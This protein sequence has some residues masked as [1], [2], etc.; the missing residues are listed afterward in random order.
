MSTRIAAHSMQGITGCESVTESHL[1]NAAA[2]SGEVCIRANQYL[3]RI[4]TRCHRLAGT[5]RCVQQVLSTQP[6]RIL[7]GTDATCRRRRF[8]RR[9]L[10]NTETRRY[11]RAV[12]K[13]PLS[14]R[15]TSRLD[16][17]M[18]RSVCFVQ[19]GGRAN[20][21]QPGSSPG[22][23]RSVNYVPPRWAPVPRQRRAASDG[24]T[25]LPRTQTHWR[26]SQT[27]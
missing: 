19:M 12:S 11:K 2:N 20:A 24:D 26:G 21:P 27:L 9:W 18:D 16:S 8:L 10:R 7:A 13:F 15:V 23:E 4:S 25:R 14:G 1:K 5:F 17:T 6:V 22:T 3:L